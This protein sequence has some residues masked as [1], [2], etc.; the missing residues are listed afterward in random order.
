MGNDYKVTPGNYK[1]LSSTGC[2]GKTMKNENDNSMMKNILSDLGYTCVGDR[3][4]KR[5]TLFTK[6]LH[7]LAGDIQN[8]TFVEITDDSDDLQ[9]EVYHPI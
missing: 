8:K 4:S 6:T 3:D 1:T 7:E 9:G 2:T 5:K